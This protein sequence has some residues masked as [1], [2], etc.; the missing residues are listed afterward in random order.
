MPVRI[1]HFGGL[2]FSKKSVGNRFLSLFIIT[3]VLDQLN[4]LYETSALVQLYPQYFLWIY[5]I[6]LL[7]GP[8]IWWHFKKVRN[9]EKKLAYKELLHLLPFVLFIVLGLFPL[10][11]LSGADRLLFAREHFMEYVVPLNYIRSTHVSVYAFHLVFLI[12]KNKLYSTD[13]QGLYLT[14]IT[15]VFVLAALVQSYLTAFADDYGQFAIYYTLVAILV[16]I[17]GVMLYFF[18]HII[19]RV[20]HK[21]FHS[22]LT[23]KDKT[24]ILQKLETL[25]KNTAYFLKSDLKLRILSDD[26]NE[27]QHHISEVLS[28]EMNSSFIQYVNKHRIDFTKDLLALPENKKT[29]LLAIA[30]DSGFNNTVTFNKAFVKETGQTPGKYRK[31]FSDS[32]N[33]LKYSNKLS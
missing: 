29:K 19:E 22:N 6:C 33:D 31:H 16:V 26:L 13:T 32:D 20:H 8:L 2:F 21:Y 30:F 11:E 3:L 5:P 25:K 18:P 12:V 28:K 14:I 1:F 17:P 10:Y 9:P 4:F 7:F 27:K 15:L 23:L 24:R